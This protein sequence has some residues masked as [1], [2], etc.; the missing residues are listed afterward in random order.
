MKIDTIAYVPPVSTDIRP[1]IDKM[2]MEFVVD[3][4]ATWKSA[5]SEILFMVYR[6]SLNMKTEMNDKN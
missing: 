1:L 3:R 5:E 4:T 2:R 6:M